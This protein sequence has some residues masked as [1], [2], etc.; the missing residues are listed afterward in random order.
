MTTKKP[1][2]QKLEGAFKLIPP[3]MYRGELVE[4]SVHEGEQ[5]GATLKFR[6][7]DGPHRG[8]L[9]YLGVGPGSHF[10]ALLDV[11]H[12]KHEGIMLTL[13]QGLAIGSLRKETE[14]KKR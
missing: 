3:G 11:R 8:R 6:I 14:E 1:K 5:A 10:R 7:T 12:Q 9:V 2:M 13:V 4:V